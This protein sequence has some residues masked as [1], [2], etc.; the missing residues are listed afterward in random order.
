M[1]TITCDNCGKHTKFKGQYI[2][3]GWHIECFDPII[4]DTIYKHFCPDCYAKMKRM[5]EA[6]E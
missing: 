3:E 4:K 6:K 1:I 2:P 5:M